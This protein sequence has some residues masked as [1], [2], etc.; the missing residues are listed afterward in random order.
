MRNSN[1]PPNR[2]F[3]ATYN[4]PVVRECDILD[5]DGHVQRIKQKTGACQVSELYQAVS[6]LAALR[7]ARL[8]AKLLGQ[9][10]SKEFGDTI[11]VEVIAVNEGWPPKG[12]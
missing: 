7:V 5:K 6:A 4:V 11:E 9:A 2:H 3:Q 10:L 8:E 1:P 12:T